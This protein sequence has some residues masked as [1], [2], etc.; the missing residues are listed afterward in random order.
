MLSLYETERL[1]GKLLEQDIDIG[2]LIV[3]Q[4]LPENCRDSKC[5]MC[6]SRS[7]MQKK[8]L[9]QIDEDY[10]DFHVIKIPMEKNEIRGPQDLEKFC[11]FYLGN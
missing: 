8:Y 3:N 9:N 6:K 10:C 4:I 2:N 5:K 11:K 7:N 1:V